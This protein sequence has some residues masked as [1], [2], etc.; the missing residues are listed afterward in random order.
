MIHH[1]L[2][3]ELS[4]LNRHFVLRW[5]G[6]DSLDLPINNFKLYRKE[7]LQSCHRNEGL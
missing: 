3:N 4:P 7:A 1:Y 5:S 2:L 6:L